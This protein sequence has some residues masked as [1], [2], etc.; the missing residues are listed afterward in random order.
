MYANASGH[1]QGNS[2]CLSF[3][4]LAKARATSG[5]S[6]AI[7]ALASFLLLS[8]FIMI[9]LCRNPHR[10]SGYAVARFLAKRLGPIGRD[11]TGRG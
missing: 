3:V 10:S 1:S 7:L 4:T 2:F 9:K 8:M 5:A 11:E 6:S